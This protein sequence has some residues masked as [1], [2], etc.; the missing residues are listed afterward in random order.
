M[1]DP[2]QDRRLAVSLDGDDLERWNAHV[3]RLRET[4]RLLGAAVKINEISVIIA[5]PLTPVFRLVGLPLRPLALVTGGLV[6]LLFRL[7]LTPFFGIVLSMSSLWATSPR[8]RPF[9]MLTG[10]VFVVVSLWLL[11]LFPED[12]EIRDAKISLCKIWPLSRRR[13]QWIRTHGV[14]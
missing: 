10:P 12:P 14:Y 2:E 8:S 4:E 7:L 13:L 9:L 5:S 11:A 6:H 1:S 3:V